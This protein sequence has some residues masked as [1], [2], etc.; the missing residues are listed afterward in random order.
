MNKILEQINEIYSYD[1]GNLSWED[2]SKI[3]LTNLEK[4]ILS[5][6]EYDLS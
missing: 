1:P 4:K 6:Y 2:A 5:K 3:N